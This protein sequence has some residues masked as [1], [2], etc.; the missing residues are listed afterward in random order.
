MPKFFDRFLEMLR[1][2]NDEQGIELCTK[3]LN[4]SNR[5]EMGEVYH[6][7]LGY[8]PTVKFDFDEITETISNFVSDN[9][10]DS[11]K[12]NISKIADTA[13]DIYIERR[14][15]HQSEAIQEAI[16]QVVGQE[17]ADEFHEWSWGSDSPDDDESVEDDD[18]DDDDDGLDDEDVD[19]DEFN[20]DDE[21]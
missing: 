6:K 11:S 2:S 12:I 5:V 8:D 18:F 3:L 10:I 17:M 14:A 16:K 1:T 9:E 20:P 21:D 19:D 4:P 13:M 7:T 15:D